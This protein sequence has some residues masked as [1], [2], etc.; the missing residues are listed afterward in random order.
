MTKM[1][2]LL[3]GYNTFVNLTIVCLDDNKSS[4]YSSNKYVLIYNLTEACHAQKP[5]HTY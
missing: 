1:D 5:F 2:H 3:F 4:V